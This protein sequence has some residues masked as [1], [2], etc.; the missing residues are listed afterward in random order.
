MDDLEPPLRYP[1]YCT[2]EC[3]GIHVC[4]QAPDSTPYKE[5]Y[6]CLVDPATDRRTY[7]MTIRKCTRCGVLRERWFRRPAM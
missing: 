1:F 2:Q 3:K 6:Y 4:C 5:W 7:M